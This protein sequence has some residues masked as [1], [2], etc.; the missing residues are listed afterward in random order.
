MVHLRLQ[1]G[2][3]NRGERV[4]AA[5]RTV[6]GRSERQSDSRLANQQV[7]GIRL[8]H[9]DKL[10]RGRRSHTVPERVHVRQSGAAS[11]LQN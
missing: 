1:F 8:R 5:V 6:R 7:Q 10:R 3:R 2:T 11:Q 4:V 9:H